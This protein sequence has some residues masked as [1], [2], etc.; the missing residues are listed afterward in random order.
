MAALLCL[1]F[2]EASSQCACSGTISQGELVKYKDHYK[3]IFVKGG[4]DKKHTQWIYLPKNYFLFLQDFLTKNPYTKGVWIY[5]LSQGKVLDPNQQSEKNQILVNIVS[6][7]VTSKPDFKSLINHHQTSPILKVDNIVHLSTRPNIASPSIIGPNE[8]LGNDE[9]EIL[10]NVVRYKEQYPSGIYSTRLFVCRA[11]IDQIVSVLTQGT[12]FGGVK[13]NFGSYGK[14]IS[15]VGNIYKNQFTLLL[16]PVKDENS[17]A[18]IDIYNAFLREKMGVSFTDI[19][20][21]GSL[22]PADCY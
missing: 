3:N 5:F 13:L 8:I 12:T 9:Y 11:Q 21:H 16:V 6:A 1:L 20:N 4:A 22:C 15:C 14:V 7:D 19:F 18:N 17:F 2:L 10:S